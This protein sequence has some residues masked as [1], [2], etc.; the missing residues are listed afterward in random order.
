MT[1]NKYFKKKITLLN[2][3]MTIMI[4][5]L[6]SKTP[7]RYGYVFDLEYP[8]MYIVCKFTQIAV[9]MFFF[10]SS[11]LFY[12]TCK[13]CDIKTKLLSRIK[14]LLIPYLMW[15]SM[16]VLIFYILLHIPILHNKMNMGEALNTWQE[17]VRAIVLSKFSV[18]W[19]VRN[20]IIYSVFAPIIFMLAKNKYM[21]ILV[22]CCLT[23]VA[24]IGNYEYESLMLWLPIY[25]MGAIIGTH[26]S[27]SKDNDTYFN[28]GS[29]LN[30]KSGIIL[31]ILLI[32]IYLIAIFDDTALFIYRIFGPMFIW[33][34]L[35]VF[36]KKYIDDNFKVRKWMSYTFF[37]FCMHHFFLNILQ[38]II[39]L[40]LPP[41][42]L[43]LNLTFIISPIII[44]SLLIVIANFIHKSSIYKIMCGNR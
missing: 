7:E 12:R 22:F 15:N 19:F 30:S 36:F 39:I 27:G 5:V 9:P 26:F 24:F 41:S 16:F 44:I 2:V 17:I 6:H 1:N 37:I 33:V 3:I 11:I 14:T 25:F 40:N 23:I 29:M 35:D 4:V 21:S 18:L 34:L 38:K 8:F 31:L 13:F 43:V 20:L 42:S 10:L 28:W 32:I